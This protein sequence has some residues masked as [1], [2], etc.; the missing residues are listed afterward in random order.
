VRGLRTAVG[1]GREHV[2]EGVQHATQFLAL[3][4]ECLREL[5]NPPEEFIR[6]LD[7]VIR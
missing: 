1:H 6:L 3:P 7:L 4:A 2:S 5:S